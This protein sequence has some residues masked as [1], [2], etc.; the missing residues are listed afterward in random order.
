[1]AEF[2]STTPSGSV[3]MGNPVV[4]KVSSAAIDS[5]KAAFHRVKM[6]VSVTGGGIPETK[7]ELSQPIAG[8]SSQVV[9]FDISSCFRATADLYQFAPITGGYSYPVFRATCV[10]KDIWVEDGLSRESA[11]SRPES[12]DTVIGRF[13]DYELRKGMHTLTATRSRKPASGELVFPGDNIVYATSTGVSASAAIVSVPETAAI[14]SSVSIPGIGKATVVPK[15]PRSRQFQFVNSRGCVESIRAFGLPSEKIVSEKKEHT[16]SRFERINQF[17]RT[18]LRKFLRPADMTFS[19]GYVSYEWAQW[20]AYEFC[21]GQQHWML[22][23]DGTWLPVLVS[24][25]DNATIIDRSKVGLCYI[26]FTV[27]PDANGGLF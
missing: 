6:E 10:V 9:E 23:P 1:M 12:F 17:S 24:I 26:E 3:F 5:D 13:S 7:Y 11:A 15:D 8:K 2:V 18:M 16:I 19:S 27:K 21:M 25:N 20:W 22:T 14:Y 4:Y